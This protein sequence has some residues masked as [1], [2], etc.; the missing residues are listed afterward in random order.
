[1]RL[2]RHAAAS[3]WP[4]DTRVP[5]TIKQVSLVLLLLPLLLFVL[6]LLLLFVLLTPMSAPY[7]CGQFPPFHVLYTS[8]TPEIRCIYHSQTIRAANGT[9]SSLRTR[10]K[11]DGDPGGREC[12]CDDAREFQRCSDQRLRMQ[13]C[14]SKQESPAICLP[15]PAL[16]APTTPPNDSVRVCKEQSGATTT[17]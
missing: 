6:T 16:F 15:S 7:S 1:M 3:S 8:L 4:A 11:D 5:S 9:T 12:A 2:V 14:L 10:K 13:G 17:W